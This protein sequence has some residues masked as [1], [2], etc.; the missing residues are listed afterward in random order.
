MDDRGG[1]DDRE[2]AV[3]VPA[4]L[5]ARGRPPIL[6]AGMVLAVGA[7]VV[8]GAL[9][10]LDAPGPGTAEGVPDASAA[11]VIVTDT[12]RPASTRTARAPISAPPDDLI[13]LDLRPDGRHLFVHGDVFSLEAFIV[14]VSLEDQGVVAETRTVSMPGGSTA[15]LTD[16]NP[17]FQARFDMPDE[18]SSGSLWVRANAYD[19][20][21]DLILSLRQ[22]VLLAVHSSPGRAGNGD[23]ELFA[24][25]A[26][27]SP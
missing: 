6:G 10:Q 3:F 17:R 19:T 7:L 18:A 22:E 15:F 16:A 13:K 21:G 12:P 23:F 4:P 9:D 2:G 14:V 24:A 5:R 27:G 20:H 25:F 11:A 8:I 1:R 26:S